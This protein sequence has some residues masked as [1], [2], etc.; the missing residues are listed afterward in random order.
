MSTVV[1]INIPGGVG[2]SYPADAPTHQL[3]ERT[4]T[5]GCSCNGYNYYI[6]GRY[7]GVS[8]VSSASV[9]V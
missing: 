6:Q 8:I 9:K 7:N 5:T 3:Y 2:Y 4:G 1:A